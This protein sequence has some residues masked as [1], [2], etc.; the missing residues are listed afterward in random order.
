MMTL[1]SCW[2][3]TTVNKGYYVVDHGILFYYEQV[4]GQNV[5][6][7]M[8]LSINVMPYFSWPMILYLMVI[9]PSGRLVNAFVCRFTAQS[10]DKVSSSM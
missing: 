4:E 10:Y 6:S 8:C 5:V 9:F 3:M 1:A 2:E 7:C